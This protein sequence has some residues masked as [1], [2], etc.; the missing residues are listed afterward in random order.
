MGEGRGSRAEASGEFSLFDA[1]CACDDL[2]LRYGGHTQAAGLTIE[3]E[4]IDSFRKRVL[5]YACRTQDYMPVARLNIDSLLSPSQATLDL[6]REQYRLEPFGNGNEAPS[7]GLMGCRL[8]GIYPVSGGK[9]LR[10]RLSDGRDSLYV[11]YFGMQQAQFP[12]QVETSWIRWYPSPSTNTRGRNGSARW[13]R[14][15]GLQPWTRRGCLLRSRFM[16]KSGGKNGSREE[17]RGIALPTREDVAA[18]YRFIRSA[19]RFAYDYDILYSRMPHGRLNYCRARLCADILG[20]MKLIQFRKDP[21]I[22]YLAAV[23][24]PGKVDLSQSKVL[25]YVRDRA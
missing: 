16:K 19:G 12:Y 21:C 23:Q 3:T 25:Q 2:L 17:E 5:E 4:K 20:E 18:V 22:A 9:H 1:L 7:Y 10:L 11:M 6:V 13:S 15:C 24:N 14:I 8:T